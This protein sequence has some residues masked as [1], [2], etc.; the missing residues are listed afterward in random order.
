MC[1][2]VYLPGKRWWD[3]SED[4]K[5]QA[6]YHKLMDEVEGLPQ[7][8]ELRLTKRIVSTV[9][10]VESDSSFLGIQCAHVHQKSTGGRDCE[11]PNTKLE[12]NV[13]ISGT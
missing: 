2:L 11:I 10:C 9:A 8:I 6:M 13:E 3:V 1:A 4:L 12:R 5:K 7:C